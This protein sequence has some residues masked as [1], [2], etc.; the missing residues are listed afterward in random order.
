MATVDKEAV[1][2][3]STAAFNGEALQLRELVLALVADPASMPRASASP[4]SH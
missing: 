4:P 2:R 1:D 3:I